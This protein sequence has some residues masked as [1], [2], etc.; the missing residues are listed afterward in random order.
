MEKQLYQSLRTFSPR[1]HDNAWVGHIHRAVG[2]I[3]MEIVAKKMRCGNVQLQKRS[4]DTSVWGG[5]DHGV[6]HK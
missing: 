2:V 3:R 4:F 1:R 6:G 5:N